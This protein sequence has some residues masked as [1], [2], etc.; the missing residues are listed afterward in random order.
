M[1]IFV[2]HSFPKNVVILSFWT[3]WFFAISSENS[4]VE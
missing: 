4:M 3:D 1:E 2:I